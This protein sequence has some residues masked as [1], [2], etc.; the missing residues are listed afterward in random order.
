MPRFQL[1]RGEPVVFVGPMRSGKSNLIAWL[2]EG[3]DSV[4]IIDTKWHPDEW[5]SWAPKHGYVITMDPADILRHPK[6]VMRISVQALSDIRGWHREGTLG[7]RW[8]QVLQAILRRGETCVVVDETVTAL[9]PGQAHPVAIQ[10]LT[11]GAAW[12][13]TPWM[14][15][16]YANRVETM[17]IR[18]AVHCFAF[19]LQPVDR[20]LL[21][22]KRGISAEVLGRLPAYGFAYHLT[23]TPEWVVVQPVELVMGRPKQP[24]RQ[25]ESAEIEPVEG[26]QRGAKKVI[27]RG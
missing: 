22:E 24:I 20:K 1:A 26:E 9:P 27:S 4:V 11:Q 16:Q 13:I 6:V 12:G 7:H 23:N 19:A 18:S 25:A 3:V 14:G 21:G 2:L 5:A 10:I 8:T 17:T 15:T